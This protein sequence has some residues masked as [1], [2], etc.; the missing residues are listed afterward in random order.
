[1]RI[2]FNA[3]LP[4]EV[5]SLREVQLVDAAGN[6]LPSSSLKFTMRSTM[7]SETAATM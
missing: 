5:L 1:V 2:T 6:Q 3:S 7:S 4:S